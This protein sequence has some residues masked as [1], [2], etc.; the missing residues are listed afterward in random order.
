MEKTK[1][2]DTPAYLTT[3]IT[4]SSELLFGPECGGPGSLGHGWC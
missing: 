3:T 2:G 4:N 1:H